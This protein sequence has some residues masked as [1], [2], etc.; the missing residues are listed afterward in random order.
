M[1]WVLKDWEHQRQV[2]RCGHRPF[3][4]S[5]NT[6]MHTPTWEGSQLLS[7]V[8]PTRAMGWGR[9]QESRSPRGC[10]VIKFSVVRK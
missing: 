3:T 10:S 2:S 6:P 7:Q 9:P 4:A 1:T 8:R 5:G